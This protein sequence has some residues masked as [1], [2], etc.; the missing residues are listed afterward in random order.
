MFSDNGVLVVSKTPNATLTT[1]NQTFKANARDSKS[2]QDAKTSEEDKTLK[3][4]LENE[5]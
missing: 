2:S 3:L 5:F 1:A 4:E